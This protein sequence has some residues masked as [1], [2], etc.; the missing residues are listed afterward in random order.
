MFRL[1]TLMPDGSQPFT[2]K[3]T[4]AELGMSMALSWDLDLRAGG[5]KIESEEEGCD[6]DG[7]ERWGGVGVW[8]G[9]LE[10]PGPGDDGSGRS[11]SAADAA[12]E[13]E[14][15]VFLVFFFFFFLLEVAVDGS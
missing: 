2:E 10:G 15:F 9:G 8:A 14:D 3:D 12:A 11:G 5:W 1:S 4:D 6:G 13:E 7:V